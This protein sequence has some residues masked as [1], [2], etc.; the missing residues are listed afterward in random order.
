MGNYPAGMAEDQ[1]AA[2]NNMDGRTEERERGAF[3]AKS[4]YIGAKKSQIS[5]FRPAGIYLYLESLKTQNRPIRRTNRPKN[6]NKERE[7]QS[8]ELHDMS[9]TLNTAKLLFDILDSI[10]LKDIKKYIKEYEAQRS[11]S[12]LY[13]AR[14]G[15]ILAERYI[16]ARQAVENIREQ[17]KADRAAIL[18]GKAEITIEGE[19]ENHE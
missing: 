4:P 16:A 5:D 12:C 3:I 18:N 1:P 10:T 2:I 15:L 6:L 9:K 17:D 11:P 13:H 7:V 8:R 14:E 19:N